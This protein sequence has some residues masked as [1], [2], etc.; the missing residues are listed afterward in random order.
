M[1]GTIPEPPGLVTPGD[2][3]DELASFT[4][5]MRANNV[6][7]N[8]DPGLRRRRPTVW[9]WLMDAGYPTG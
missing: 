6:S 9:R 4:R 2:L 1:T 8:T 3:G 7:P 5:P